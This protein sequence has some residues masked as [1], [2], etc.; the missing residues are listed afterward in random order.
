MQC[1]SMALGGRGRGGR[2]GRDKDRDQKPLTKEALDADLDEVR[3][4]H[5]SHLLRCPFGRFFMFLVAVIIMEFKAH[6]SV[7]PN[8][9]WRMKDKKHGGTSLD[10]ELDDYWK[11]KEDDD[12]TDKG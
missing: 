10:A 9:Q 7:L 8:L 4:E 1:I 2:G 11:N 12:P 3:E 5:V 6:P